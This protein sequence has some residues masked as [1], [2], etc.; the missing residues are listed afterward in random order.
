[1]LLIRAAEKIYLSPSPPHNFP[2]KR[3]LCVVCTCDDGSLSSLSLSLSLSFFIPQSERQQVQSCKRRL[4]NKP[5]VPLPAA[6]RP[7]WPNAAAAAAAAAA[8]RADFCRR[9]PPSSLSLSLSSQAG[10]TAW[11]FRGQILKKIWP[12]FSPQP[13]PP[14]KKL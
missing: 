14:K 7:V 10:M 5:Q 4:C 12:N 13:S 9:V 6:G 1:M 2:R 11:P 3:S 8:A